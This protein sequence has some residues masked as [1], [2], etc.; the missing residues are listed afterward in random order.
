MRMYEI[1]LYLF[2]LNAAIVI[3]DT[4]IFPNIAG[5][6]VG[7]SAHTNWIDPANQYNYTDDVNDWGNKIQKE[8]SGS[9]GLFTWFNTMYMGFVLALKTIISFF[10]SMFLGVYI[11]IVTTFGSDNPGI[12]IMAATL[13]G[14]VWLIYSIGFF[15]FVSGRDFRGGQ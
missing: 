11:F 14:A 7:T 15:Q 6:D 9:T 12:I 1:A 8:G 3:A 13:Q 4:A 5:M 2:M 10:S